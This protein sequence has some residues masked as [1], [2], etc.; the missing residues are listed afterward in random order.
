LVLLNQQNARTC[1][2]DIYIISRWL[3]MH[4]SIHKGSS[5]G[6]QTKV[7]LHKTKL[8]MCIIVANLVLCETPLVWFCIDDPLWIETCRN[9]HCDCAV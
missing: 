6:Y 5:S 3:F 8:D 2:F 7:V 4:V 9:S 1:S